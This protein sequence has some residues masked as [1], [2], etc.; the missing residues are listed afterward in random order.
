MYRY[1]FGGWS[2][3]TVKRHPNTDNWTNVGISVCMTAL[4][5]RWN[6]MASV[7]LF[8]TGGMCFEKPH[9]RTYAKSSFS[10]S[11]G[12]LIFQTIENA[13]P[14]ARMKKYKIWFECLI[15]SIVCVSG[16]F[17]KNQ[18]SGPRESKIANKCFVLFCLCFVLFLVSS[19]TIKIM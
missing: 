6:V 2:A 5:I 12:K 7:S 1:V 18:Y 19:T 11:L 14:F 15:W 17:R 10:I 3:I 13:K 8:Q 16:S 9:I 4:I